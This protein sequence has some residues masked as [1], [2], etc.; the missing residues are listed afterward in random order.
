MEYYYIASGI[1][2]LVG[3]VLGFNIKRILRKVRDVTSV[4]GDGGCN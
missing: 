2:F 3:T 4:K 1:C